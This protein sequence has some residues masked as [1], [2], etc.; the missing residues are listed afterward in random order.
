MARRER[1]ECRRITRRVELAGAAS[2]DQGDALAD[3]VGAA[4]AQVRQ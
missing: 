1:E 2:T 3:L 4:A